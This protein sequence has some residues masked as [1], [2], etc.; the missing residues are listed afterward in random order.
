[1]AAYTTI[2]DPSAYFKVQL[3]T[4]NGSGSRAIA[5]DDTDTNMLPDFVWIKARSLQ[6]NHELYDSVR[7]VQKRVMS[8]DNGAEETRSQGLLAFSSDG[9]TIGTSDGVNKNTE[10]YV[11]WNWKAGTSFT[12]DASSTGIGTID[13]SGSVS[14]VAGFSICTY[15]GTGSNATIKH[16][17]SSAPHVVWTKQ[18]NATQKWITYN[19]S[20]GAANTLHL[21]TTEVLQDNSAF[22]D[23]D[24]TTSVFSVGTIVNSN[25]SSGTY[26]AYSFAPIQG[27]SKV[28]G[29][30]FGNGSTNG[31]YVHCGFRPAWVMCRV[32]GVTNDW[33]I[34]DNT[35]DS[36]N[37]SNS[38][39][40]ANTDG[41]ESDT[42]RADF[43]AN[44]FKIRG[45]GN[46]TNGS[47]QTY[48]FMAFAESPFVNS[49]GV[50]NNAR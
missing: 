15:T 10:T 44:G 14:D 2:D 49:N 13:S 16:G 46:D 5:F 18:R 4:G 35:R 42:D 7:G 23:T 17:L 39:L 36:F 33:T 19:K 45:D 8:N 41:T 34:L 37:V 50:P 26:V 43:L 29:K 32:T 20:L 1:M 48:T 38:R 40:Y 47:G 31:P 6:D 24:P 27:F 22:N 12:N 28:G 11:S 3:W 9:F 21:D 30:Y 25:E